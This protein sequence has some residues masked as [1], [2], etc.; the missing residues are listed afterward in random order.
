MES[1]V[2]SPV[3]SMGKEEVDLYAQRHNDATLVAFLRDYAEEGPAWKKRVAEAQR[4]LTTGLDALEAALGRLPWLSGE[5]YGLADISWVVN[6]NRLNQ[7]QVDLAKWPRFQDWARRAIERPAFDRA[8][9][10]WR[11]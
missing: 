6:A 1:P 8:V 3:D 10:S 9:A 5:A 2:E 11:P 7:A 4:G